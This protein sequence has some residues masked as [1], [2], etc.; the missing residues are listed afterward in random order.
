MR[1]V[2]D[3]ANTD[4]FSITTSWTM[5]FGTG[6]RRDC[7]CA[8]DFAGADFELRQ[9]WLFL[10]GS[11]ERSGCAPKWRGVLDIGEFNPRRERGRTALRNSGFDEFDGRLPD[12]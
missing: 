3:Y 4:S 5:R 12:V 6:S 9:L 7:A 1:S 11:A 10:P 2:I 8:P